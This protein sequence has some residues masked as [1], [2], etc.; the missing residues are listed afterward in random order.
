M[1]KNWGSGTYDI[2]YQKLWK[3]EVIK[4]DSIIHIVTNK[5]NRLSVRKEIQN[6]RL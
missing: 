5:K 4:Q 2:S 6:V 3:F 1:K